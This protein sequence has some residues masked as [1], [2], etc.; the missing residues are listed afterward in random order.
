MPV[1]VTVPVNTSVP[2]GVAGWR[3]QAAVTVIWGEVTNGQVLVSVPVTVL[4]VQRSWPVT[5][6]VLVTA[7]ASQGAL[8][9]LLKLAAAPGAKAARLNTVVLGTG[10]LLTTVRLVSV[11]LPVLR[12]LPP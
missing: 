3:G 7:H 4:P 6:K 12:T 11:L 8:K 2:P 5:I 9:L 1:L 10:W